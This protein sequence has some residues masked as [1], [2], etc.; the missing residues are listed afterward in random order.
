[1]KKIKGIFGMLLCLSLSFPSGVRA[2]NATLLTCAALM[3]APW[4]LSDLNK[5]AAESVR[6]ERK[7][8]KWLR[9][10][11]ENEQR[12]YA[13]KI[14]SAPVSAFSL[15][16][17]VSHKLESS[18]DK[19]L[20]ALLNQK[21]SI[22]DKDL[23]LFPTIKSK[24]F[25][26]QN[27]QDFFDLPSSDTLYGYIYEECIK[28]INEYESRLQRERRKGEF[29]L[30]ENNNKVLDSKG[31]PIRE[32]DTFVFV[33]TDKNNRMLDEAREE[34]MKKYGI[35]IE[36]LKKNKKSMVW[37]KEKQAAVMEAWDILIAG[38][39]A[40]NKDNFDTN[41]PL[42]GLEEYVPVFN[43]YLFIYAYLQSLYAIKIFKRPIVLKGVATTALE[44]KMHQ[45]KRL[46][47][48]EYAM[49]FITPLALP[50]EPQKKSDVGVLNKL[51][52]DMTKEELAVYNNT[53]RQRYIDKGLP[54]PQWLQPAPPKGMIA[55][56][57]PKGMIATVAPK[58]TI[59]TV[60]PKG[61]IATIKSW[62]GWLRN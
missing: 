34:Y 55:T 6:I 11:F 58:G 19:T 29:I 56:V 46:V 28:K 38:F 14:G 52:Q 43:A 20:E 53:Q 36:E 62:F 32:E 27:I 51:P 2:M 9:E 45:A 24:I 7:K 57:A 21:L 8:I 23:F 39:R 61:M 15:A 50:T 5:K 47:A 3:M 12:L 59:A 54:V 33:D 44:E 48:S 30:D 37:I 41:K 40:K 16:F 18:I 10:A 42:Q 60:A 17:K 26:L 4:V 35:T 22:M 13:K 31:N 49:K 1:M 25:V